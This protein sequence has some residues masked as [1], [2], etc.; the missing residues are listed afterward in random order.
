MDSSLKIVLKFH[1]LNRG[2][3]WLDTGNFD[4]LY[5]AATY[6]KTLENRTGL[7]IGCPEEV[8]WRSNLIS[9]NDL[10]LLGKKFSNNAY[11]EYLLRILSEGS[12]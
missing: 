9:D 5:N 10:Y 11:G 7:K 1:K 8:A 4:S 12:E 3:A 2:I 6:I